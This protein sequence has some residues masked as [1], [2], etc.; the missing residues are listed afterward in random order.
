MSIYSEPLGDGET[1][2][3]VRLHRERGDLGRGGNGRQQARWESSK[4]RVTV[5]GKPREGRG[6]S[7]GGTEPD[8]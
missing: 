8:G 2:Q 1:A 7:H 6:V 3:D 4:S 5:T